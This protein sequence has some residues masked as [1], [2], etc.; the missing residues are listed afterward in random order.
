MRSLST[1][2]VTGESLARHEY[3]GPSNLGWAPSRDQVA[4]GRD[5]YLG[6]IVSEGREPIEIHVVVEFE[7]SA[8]ESRWPCVTN[9]N[10][11]AGDPSNAW[12]HHFTAYY[13]ESETGG[14][15]PLDVIYEGTDLSLLYERLPKVEIEWKPRFVSWWI[16]SGRPLRL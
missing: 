10:R 6:L 13:C 7:G 4:A 8:V 3:F 2:G 12:T 15:R 5:Y 14:G 16:A 1:P 11:V 9:I